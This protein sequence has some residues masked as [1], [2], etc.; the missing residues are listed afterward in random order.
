M[1]LVSREVQHSIA[2]HDVKDIV[3]K[4]HGFNHLHAEISRRQGGMQPGCEA[5]NG[6]DGVRIGVHAKYLVVFA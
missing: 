6:C 3:G 1:G 2:Q 4:R 5:T